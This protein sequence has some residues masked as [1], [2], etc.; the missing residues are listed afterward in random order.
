MKLLGFHSLYFDAL[1][2]ASLVHTFPAF[3]N[4]NGIS[5]DYILKFSLRIVDI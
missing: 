4:L 3:Q 2:S 1:L 5:F